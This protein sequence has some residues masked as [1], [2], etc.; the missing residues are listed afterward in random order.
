[1]TDRAGPADRHERAE[2]PGVAE[3]NLWIG[4]LAVLLIVVTPVLILVFSNTGS[5][6][7]SWAEF[8]W[9][10]PLWLV[11]TVT[12]IAGGV[13]TRLAAWMWRGWRGRRRRLKD[14]R[15]ML[16]RLG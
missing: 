3:P 16:R 10:G 12:F 1:M 8:S 9:E 15:Y 14:E 4:P 6:P 2:R 7:V 13:V 11:L 5:V